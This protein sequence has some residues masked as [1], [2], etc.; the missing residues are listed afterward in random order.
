MRINNNIMAMNTHRQYAINNDNLAKATE[1]L[2]SGYRINSAADDAAG[3]AISEKM[4]AQIRGLDMASK[5][6][7]DAISL[8]QTAEGALEE[9]ESILQR[10]REL[11]VQSASDTNEETVDRAALDAEY[12][13]LM[14]EI[15]D[16]ATKTA[17]NKRTL[18]DGSVGTTYTAEYGAGSTAA[19]ADQTAITAGMTI[20]MDSDTTTMVAGT[21][22]ATFSAATAESGSG[23]NDATAATMELS[24]GAGHTYTVAAGADGGAAGATFAAGEYDIVDGS[25]NVVGTLT[26]NT[27]A[28]GAVDNA[29]AFDEYSMEIEVNDITFQTG[30]NEGD[31]LA[32]QIGNGFCTGRG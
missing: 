22:T 19:G 1:K 20:A 3:L 10:M 4:R 31:T 2:S 5:N 24:D 9:T 7:E 25:S 16:I 6:S 27:A 28:A 26:L 30:A 11:A 12:Q 23:A 13:Q 14:E 8:V 32:I 15:D 18:I 29:N 21:Y 17:F